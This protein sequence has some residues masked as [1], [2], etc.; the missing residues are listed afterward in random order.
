MLLPPEYHGDANDPSGRALTYRAY[1]VD[2]DGELAG[3]G[4]SV[5]YT[6]VD[7][8]EWAIHDTEL[9][10]CRVERPVREP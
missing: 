6:R 8:P 7:F 9:F 10:Y 2:L 4:F 1:G 3:L 5:E